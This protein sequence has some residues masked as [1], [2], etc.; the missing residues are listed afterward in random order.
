MEWM[1]KKQRSKRK[2]KKKRHNIPLGWTHSD[3][4]SVIRKQTH[5]Q[6]GWFLQAECFWAE[7]E[8][9]RREGREETFTPSLQWAEI[10]LWLSAD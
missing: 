5:E 7:T 1:Q 3:F 2:T 10:L 6:C 8:Q 4:C 9:D